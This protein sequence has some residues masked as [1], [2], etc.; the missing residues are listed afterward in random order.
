MKSITK[1]YRFFFLLAIIV[2]PA[3]SFAQVEEDSLE[4]EV[5][6]T[7]TLFGAELLMPV[8]DSVHPKNSEQVDEIL[9]FAKRFL[10]TPYHYA[11]STPSGFDCSGF[12]YYVMG[13]FGVELT[14]SSYGLAEFGETVKL[15][16]IRPGDLMFF[17]GRN[18]NS[19][20][21]GHVALVVE[22]TPDAIRFIHASTSRG[23]VIDNF[24]S[25]KYYIPRFIKAK[26]LDYGVSE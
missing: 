18:A 13:N 4:V 22:V 26:R 20:K 10:G 8:F 6:D 7:T 23:V 16:D 3:F 2:L 9:N 1:A 24:K 11:G 21:V 15:A 19:T 17:K 14:R 5:S 25:S 12:I